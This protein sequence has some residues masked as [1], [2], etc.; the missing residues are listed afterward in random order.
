MT[1]LVAQWE[2]VVPEPGLFLGTPAERYHE[3][4]CPEPSL[5]ASVAKIALETC[6]N[7]A[8]AAHPRLRLP[9]Y[10]EEPM[11]EERTPPWYMEVGSAVHSLALRSG[12]PVVCIQ[13]MNWRKKDAQDLRDQY[14]NEGCIPLLTKHYDIAQRMALRLQPVLFNLMGVDF[15]AE[16]MACSQ[17]REFGWWTRSLLDG[18][19]V[20]LRSVVELKTTQMSVAPRAVGRT[21]N[22]NSNHFQSSFYLR[23]LD[24]LD[25]QGMGRRRYHWIHQEVEYPHEISVTHPD[26]ALKSAGDDLVAMAMRRW[27]EAMTTG[28]F[29]GYPGQSMPVGP[30]NWMLRDLEERMTDEEIAADA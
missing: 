29:P 20:D 1:F 19:A 17:D 23:N 2:G 12:Q 24:N 9:D 13:A 6:L 15:A 3:D 28:E 18:S 21:I 25:P 7:K 8:R 16:A 22:R 30:E 4:P 5:S 14:R 10:P 27:N 26:E 11:A